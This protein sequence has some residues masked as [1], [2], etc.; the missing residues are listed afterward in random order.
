[1]A[2]PAIPTLT[3][4]YDVKTFKLSWG[5]IAPPAGGG[6]VT[7][8]VTEDPDGAGPAAA[9]QIA[10]GLTGTSYDRVVTG[11]LHTRLNATYRVQA[12]NTAGF[13]LPGSVGIDRVFTVH[14]QTC[15]GYHQ[16]HLNM[17]NL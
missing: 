12:C 2:V 11:L 3:L 1:M 15:S 16:T 8:R 4:A 14:A 17:R 13:D 7:Y 10:T 6:A 5:A 9:T